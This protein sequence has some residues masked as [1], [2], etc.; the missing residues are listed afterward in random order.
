MNGS[1]VEMMRLSV[2]VISNSEQ[3]RTILYVILSPAGFPPS[4]YGIAIKCYLLNFHLHITAATAISTTT[5]VPPA[6]PLPYCCRQGDGVTTPT[7]LAQ[8]T[9]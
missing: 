8:L 6:S 4:D 5:I 1:E 9:S 3:K 2:D 7:Q